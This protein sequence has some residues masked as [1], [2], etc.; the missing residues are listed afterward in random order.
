[1]NTVEASTTRSCR[2]LLQ[3]AVRQPL[4]Q[5]L[6]SNTSYFVKVWKARLITGDMTRSMTTVSGWQLSSIRVQPVADRRIEG[7]G[8]F[9]LYVE[10][11]VFL[12]YILKISEGRALRTSC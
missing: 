8:Y 11:R 3:R 6:V 9:S 5:Y 7:L 1:M 4:S 10:A 2:D 12:C